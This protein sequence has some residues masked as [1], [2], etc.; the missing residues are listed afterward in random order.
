ME[1]SSSIIAVLRRGKLRRWIDR[2]R[3]EFFLSVSFFLQM[4]VL[5]FW[6]TPS[7]EFNRLDRLVDE[8]AFV[9]NLVIQEPNVGE[10]ADDGEFEVTDTIKKKEDPRIAG[11]QDAIISGAT[12]PV[13]LTPNVV[14]DYPSEA[15]S[16]GITGTSTLELII[17]DNGQVLRV[18]SVGKSLG[19][20]LEEAAINAF[21]KKRY[22]PSVLDGKPITVKVLIPVRFSLY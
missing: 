2:Y 5:F 1:R 9:D 6:Y 13:D 7:V 4:F 17:A 8:V 22:S 19:F 21:Y 11:A 14:P 3:I 12:T 20:G 16:A 18:R 15:R 10:A